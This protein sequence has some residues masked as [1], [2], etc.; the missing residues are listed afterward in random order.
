M[1]IPE[2]MASKIQLSPSTGCW[3]WTS[4]TNYAGYAHYTLAAKKVVRVH[5]YLYQQAKGA[6]PRGL[7]LDHLC[8]KR[9]CVNPDHLEAVTQSENIARGLRPT[10][11][12]HGSKL[13]QCKRG[14]EFNSENTTYSSR[15]RRCRVCRRKGVRK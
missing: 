1:D 13:M 3:L 8:R 6:V 15:G 7:V 11:I 9:N 14:H 5:R 4:A 10:L 2:R 12:H